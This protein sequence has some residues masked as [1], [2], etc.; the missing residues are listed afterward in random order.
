VISDAL[1]L[2]LLVPPVRRLVAARIRRRAEAWVASGSV[3]IATQVRVMEINEIDPPAEAPR[4]VID[5]E[6]YTVEARPERLLA[7]TMKDEPDAKP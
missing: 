5:V 1:G 2:L 6:G 3:R 4:E 7:A